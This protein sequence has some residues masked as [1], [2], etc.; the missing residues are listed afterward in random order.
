M[1]RDLQTHVSLSP[2]PSSYHAS[3][4]LFAKMISN[5]KISKALGV[6]V[7]K[8]LDWNSEGKMSEIDRIAYQTARSRDIPIEIQNAPLYTDEVID[9][10]VNA[11][12]KDETVSKSV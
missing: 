4:S 12:Q 7:A 2:C 3:S 8:L 6:P 9:R 1:R 10:L 5:E 11:I